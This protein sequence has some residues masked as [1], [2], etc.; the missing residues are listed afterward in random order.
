M[1]AWMCLVT[2]LLVGGRNWGP[3]HGKPVKLEATSSIQINTQ[4][5]S[6]FGVYARELFSCKW[7]W[8]NWKCSGYQSGKSR[9][10]KQGCIITR[11][12][13]FFTTSRACIKIAL[14]HWWVRPAS[15][16]QLNNSVTDYPVESWF[17]PWLF[18]ML[19]AFWPFPTPA[20][21]QEYSGWKL[22]RPKSVNY[23]S[24]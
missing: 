17:R 2:G 3:H 13:I 9:S 15:H 1:C 23:G 16:T 19:P 11:S 21:W 4:S 6:V 20:T 14:K 10:L 22:V 7:V 24:I 18:P 5:D 8:V 12:V